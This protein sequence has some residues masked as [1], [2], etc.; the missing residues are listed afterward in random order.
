MSIKINETWLEVLKNEFEKAYFLDLKSFLVEEKKNHIIYPPGN[1][2][3]EAFNLTPFDQ[4]KV[5]LLGQD[6]Y[7]GA[8]QAHGLCFS[9]QDGI[10]PPPSLQ[11]IFK[12]IETDI[13]IAN[14]NKGNLQSWAKQGVLL[15]NATLTVRANQAASHQN[16]GWEIF[17]DKVIS[18]LSENKKGLIFILWGNYAQAKSSLIDANKHHI[19]KAAHPSPFSVYRGFFGCRHFSK[20]NDLLRQ[21]GK[22]EI[23]WSV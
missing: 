4:V 23:D 2:I 21:M 1:Q 3:F 22:P 8:G 12:E 17:T 7:H 9:V 19:L 18:E 20:T 13:G 5:V 15:L 6:P 11:N 14:S 16:K 10:K